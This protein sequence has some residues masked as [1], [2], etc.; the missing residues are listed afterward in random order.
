MS[1]PGPMTNGLKDTA[2][3]P[4]PGTTKAGMN[5]VGKNRGMTLPTEVPMQ[6]DDGK[7]KAR[8]RV[9]VKVKERKV[10]VRA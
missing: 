3:R 1:L 9:K 2:G 7:A 6:S 5:T 4:R 10:K 8:A